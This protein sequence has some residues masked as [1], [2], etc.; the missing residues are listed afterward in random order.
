[1]FKILSML[2]LACIPYFTQAEIAK[3]NWQNPKLRLMRFSKSG[4]FPD[5][6]LHFELLPLKAKKHTWASFAAV[7]WT[8]EINDATG[9]S[10]E[11]KGGGSKYFASIFFSYSKNLFN[12]Y[13]AVFPLASKDWKKIYIPFDRFI[14]NDLPWSVKGKINSDTLA[15]KPQAIKYIGIGRGCQFHKFQPKTCAFQIRNIVLEKVVSKNKPAKY[16]IGLNKTLELIKNKKPV[17]ILLLGD[18]ITDFGR[19]RTYAYYC[20]QMITKQFGSRVNVLNC[21]IAGHTVRGGSIVLP[22][23]LRTC[24]DPDLVCIFYG[25]N[26][27]KAVNPKSGF[28][29]EAFQA[30][31]EKLIDELRVTTAGKADILLING[32]PRLEKNQKLKSSG[33][34][35][36]IVDGVKAAAKDKQ[37]SYLDTFDAYIKLEPKQRLRY[38]RDT[39][40]QNDMGQRFIAD[41][42]FR[43]IKTTMK[44]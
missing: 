37:T 20:G 33:E 23:S 2:C 24:P 11:V 30:Q 6:V 43:K 21:G 38:Y 8:P 1:M 15:L 26:D 3:I 27:C 16:S 22:R 42:M 7:P 44:D 34:V 14:Q 35:E 18:S 13:E 17:K 39:I 10:F 28:G 9:I 29:P 31:L 25:A 41:L 40:H 12:G 4:K 36:K 32:V 5:Q 19:S